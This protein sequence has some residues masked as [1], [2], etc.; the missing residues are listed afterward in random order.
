M[1]NRTTIANFIE[2]FCS[3]PPDEHDA[4]L[5]AAPHV[6]HFVDKVTTEQ[7]PTLAPLPLRLEH[8]LPSDTCR[9]AR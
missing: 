9:G 3:L 2:R 6:G 5:S 1:L 8:T 4:L 7:T